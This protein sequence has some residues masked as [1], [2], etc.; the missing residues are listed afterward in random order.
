MLEL[1]SR[2]FHLCCLAPE[3]RQEALITHQQVLGT[4][5]L[6]D[7]LDAYDLELELEVE[8]RLG[9]LGS[10]QAVCTREQGMRTVCLT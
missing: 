6:N 2:S 8:Q 1:D 4:D 9:L 3:A 7:Y 5:L 10:K